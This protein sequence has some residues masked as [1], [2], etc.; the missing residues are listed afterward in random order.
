M[1]GIFLPYFD[2]LICEFHVLQNAYTVYDLKAA[3]KPIGVPKFFKIQTYEILILTESY[4][5][6]SLYVYYF[7]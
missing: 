7:T 1:L 4:R 2:I 5:P 3:N 6:R